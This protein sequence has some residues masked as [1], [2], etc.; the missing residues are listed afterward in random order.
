MNPNR[1]FYVFISVRTQMPPKTVQGSTSD[2]NYYL[3]TK[4]II[5]SD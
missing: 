3:Q 2:L 1:C 4:G 5:K